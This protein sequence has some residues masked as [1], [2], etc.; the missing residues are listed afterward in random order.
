MSST[1]TTNTN[2]S[3][4]E[5]S[6]LLRLKRNGK[7]KKVLVNIK[8]VASSSPEEPLQVHVKMFGKAQQIKKK[9][10]KQTGIPIMHQ[11]LILTGRK[12]DNNERVSHLLSNIKEKNEL[13]MFLV[14]NKGGSNSPLPSESI[15]TGAPEDLSQHQPEEDVLRSTNGTHSTSSLDDKN[16]NMDN[17]PITASR[18][19]PVLKLS[20]ED[21][22]RRIPFEGDFQQLTSLCTLF[23]GVKNTRRMLLQY[24]DEDGDLVQISTDAEFAYALEFYATN[25]KPR[26]LKLKFSLKQCKNKRYSPED[27]ESSL[28]LS[29]PARDRSNQTRA[30]PIGRKLQEGN[31]IQLSSGRFHLALSENN[32]SQEKDEDEEEEAQEEKGSKKFKKMQPQFIVSASSD[33]SEASQWIV[34]KPL[35]KKMKK[36]DKKDEHANV[37]SQKEEPEIIFLKN[38]SLS[39]IGNSH[40]SVNPTGEKV[41]HNGANGPWARLC[42]EYVGSSDGCIRLRSVGRSKLKKADAAANAF[43]GIVQSKVRADL[44]KDDNR[45]IFNVR[46][47]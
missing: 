21:H 39:A 25:T 35:P 5:Q 23:F 24:K 34:E 37:D 28:D 15:D 18:G 38:K 9:I 41:F 42:V 13:T 45:A 2:C 40:L 46:F 44:N 7:C 43:L 36:N 17:L 29:T 1:T 10:K 11:V 20:F 12:V 4:L 16:N 3:S 22:H 32:S 26:V 31:V 30:L 33:D 8:R 14:V 47:I 19:A 6:D 27:N